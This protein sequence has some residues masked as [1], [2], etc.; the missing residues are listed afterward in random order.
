MDTEARTRGE[1]PAWKANPN[2]ALTKL[3]PS[4]HWPP[5]LWRRFAGKT[6][7]LRSLDGANRQKVHRRNETP[8]PLPA[9]W[10][11]NS[12]A[13]AGQPGSC[14]KGQYPPGDSRMYMNTKTICVPRT[15]TMPQREPVDRIF[16]ALP[17]WSRIAK[18]CCLDR[19]NL[20]LESFVSGVQ[21]F[22]L[23]LLQIEPGA[24]AAKGLQA[25]LGDVLVG[26]AYFGR[27]L[28]QTWRSPAHTITLAVST[29]QASALWQ[30]TTFDHSDILIAGPET[31]IEL[32]SRPGFGVASVSFPDRDFQRAAALRGC[33]SAFVQHRCILVRL[34]SPLAAQSIR[35][36]IQTM[37]SEASARSVVSRTR[38]ER[39]MDPDDLL[40]RIVHTVAGGT[41]LDPFKINR[42]RAQVLEQTVSAIKERPAEVL[43]VA[44]LRR[45]SGASERTL[46]YAFVERYGMPPARFMKACRLNGARKDLCGI[47]S[48]AL[49][50]SDIANKWGFWHL[51][52]FAKDYRLW[53][54]ELP[55][56]TG[57]RNSIDH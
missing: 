41:P 11:Q 13:A 49:K 54:G 18:P 12:A 31:T 15:G 55:S 30:G 51:G 5:P 24:F 8:T 36:A 14:T 3:I 29:S 27:A 37:I 35:A 10:R 26:T 9:L 43:T 33:D 20:D 16:A 4:R 56:E 40:D 42:Q 53:F 7:Q 28:I 22:R 25:Y 48:R 21:G 6:A 47:D 46:H 39:Q 1:S 38:K 23:E 57:R 2:E 50:V 44:A 32:A 45:I 17:H 34:P 19:A 52:Q